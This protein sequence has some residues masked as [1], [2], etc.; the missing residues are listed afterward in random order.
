MA[1][2]VF[3]WFFLLI[4]AFLNATFREL[5]YR[6]YFSEK[7]SHQISVFSG[8]VLLSFAI[9]FILKFFPFKSVN[10]SIRAGLIWAFMTEIFELSM[11]HFSGRTFSD[12]LQ[13][14]NILEGE[15]WILIPIWLGIFPYVLFG[16]STY[17]SKS[18]QN[19]L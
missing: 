9:F 19:S 12:F 2:Y 15:F 8:I 13:T 7:I 18:N 3:S 6:N 17:K 10:Q 4:V 14:H 11:I 5:A 16:I 1:K